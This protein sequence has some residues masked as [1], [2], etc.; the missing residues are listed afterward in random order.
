MSVA[1]TELYDNGAFVTNCVASPVLPGGLSIN[2]RTC[3]ISGTPTGPLAPTTYS[4]RATNS[5]GTSRAAFV[6]LSVAAAASIL[7]YIGSTGT[8]GRVSVDMS[9]TPTSLNNNGSA[10]TSCVASPALPPG[11]SI[12]P[13]TCVISGIPTGA[14]SSTTYSITA[15]NSAG[16]SSTASVTLSVATSPTLNFT[17]AAGTSG[18][19]GAFM[20]VTPTTL[21]NIGAPIISC[22]AS[23]ALPVGLSINTTSCVISGIPT[24]PL[25]SFSYSITATNSAGLSSVATVTLS[26]ANSP[27][28]LSYSGATGTSGRVGTP[29]SVIPTTFNNNG[30]AIT[31]CVATSALPLGLSVNTTTCVISGTPTVAVASTSYFIATT[32]SVGLSSTASV[33]LSVAPSA[34]ILSYTGSTGTSGRVGTPMSVTPTTLNNNGANITNCVATPALSVGLSINPI[35]CVISGTPLATLGLTTYSVTGTN[36]AGSSSATSVTL[37]IAPSAPTLDYN[38]ASGNSGRAGAPMSVTPT[39]LKNNG[40]NI[41]QCVATPAL[42][43]GLSINPNTC[44][45]SGTPTGPLISTPYSIT[46][47]N[48][49]GSSTANV[50]L[51]IASSAPTLSYTGATGTSGS[52]GSPMSVTPTTL[53]NNGAPLSSCIVTPALSVGLSINP[54]TCVISGTPSGT[55]TSTTYSVTGTNSFGTSNAAVVTLSVAISKPTLSYANATGTSGR[56]GALMSVAPT[57]INNNGAPITNCMTTPALTVGLS[58]NPTTCVI[59]G[60][61]SGTLAPTPYSVVGTNSAGSSSAASVTLSVV[62]L[63]PPTL[64]YT[65]A[66]GTSGGVGTAMEV[67][68]TTLNNN[69][70]NIINCVANPA[71]SVGLSINPTTCVISGTPTDTLA[72]TTY[73]VTVTNSAGL[74]SAASVTLSVATAAPTLSYTGATGTSG[75]VGAPMSV[76]PTTLNNNGSA[77]TN[78]VATP[79][80]TV[81]LSI[82][83]TTCVISG[84][85]TGALTSTTYSVTG[86][87]SVGTSTAASVTLSVSISAP[88]LSYT[89]ASG[90]LGRVGAP[91]SVTPTTRNNNGAPI[92]N[93]VATPAL[94]VGLS[95]NPTTCVI[96]GTPTGTL[97]STIYSI[98]ATNSA[99]SSSS[100]SVTLSVAAA[101]SIL[102]YTGATGTSGRVGTPMS[103]T[104][105]TL[106]NNGSA[107]TNCV[108]TPALSVGLSI[109]TT[110]CVISGIPTGALSSTTYSITATNSAGSSP[111]AS[112]TLIVD[113]VPT[114]SYAD[115]TGTSGNVGALMSVTPTTLSQNGSPITSCVATPALSVGLSINPNTCVISGTP[116]SKLA[117]T[118]YSVRATNSLGTSIAASVTLSVVASVPTLSYSGAT[119]TTGRVGTLMSVTPTTLS[120]NDA[121]ITN[122]VATPV[123]SAGLSIN[124]TTCVISGTP[125]EP[126]A[127]TTYSVS[128]TNSVG[129]SIPA[130][131]T[132]AVT[133]APTLSYAWATGTTG[134]V[135]ASMT[136]TP[137]TLNNNGANITNCVATPALSVGLSISPTTCVISGTPTGPLASTTY[138]VTATNSLGTSSVATVILSVTAVPTLSYAGATGISGNVG[139]L[140]SVTPTTLNNNG[141]AITNCVANPTLTVGL[142]IN[143]TTCVI[144]GTPTAT[145]PPFSYSITATNSLGTSTAASVSLSVAPSPPTISYSGAPGILGRIGTPMSVAPTTLNNNGATITNCVASPA[146]SVGLSINPTTCVISGTPSAILASTSYSVTAT[147]SA[148]SSSVASVTLSVANIPTIS[149]AGAPGT[150]GS[151]G[152]PMSVTPTTLNN[153]GALITNCVANPALSVGLSINPTTCIISGTPTGPLASTSYTITVTNS[154]GL[155]SSASVTLSVASSAPTISYNGAAGTLGNVGALMSVAPTTLNNNGATIINCVA[156][157]ALSVGLS[158]NPTTCIISGTPSGALAS[159]TYSIRAT[160]SLGTSSAA[161]VILS[162]ASIPTLSYTSATGTT[163][164]VGSLMTVNPTALNNNGAPITNC[165]AT[166]ALTVGL[167]INTTTCVISGTPTGPLAST[168]YSV[169]ATNSAG[170]STAASVNLS[171]TSAPTLSYTAASGT[172]GRVGTPMSVTP[173][174][175]NNNGIAITNCVATPALSVGLSINTTTCVISGTPTGALA[176]TIYSITATNSAGSSPVA[177]VTLSVDAVPT[178]SYAGATGTSGRV[179]TPMTV[180]PPTLDNNGSAITNCVA[181]PALSVGLSINATTCIIS[182]NPTSR[183]NSTA[184]NITATNGAG[185]SSAASVTLSVAAVPTITY[186]ATVNSG[187]VGASMTVTPTTLNNNGSAI[188]NCVASPALSVGLSINAT[189]CVI[190]GTPTDTLPSTTYSIEATNSVGTSTKA[191]VSL[192]V[193]L[194]PNNY[195]AVPANSNLGVVKAFCAA[196]FEMKNV[197]LVATSQ[198]AGTPWVSISQTDA[199]T[200][201]TNLGP[202]YD[203]ISNPEW[204]TIAREIEKTAANWSS[205]GVGNGM[206]N[207]GHSDSTPELA[208]E[209]TDLNNPYNET[210]NNSGQSAGSGW[211]QKRKHTFSNGQEIW[212]IAGNVPEWTDW[213]FSGGLTS[214]PTSCVG[215][216]TQLPVVSCGALAAAD[217]MPAN[218]TGV[219][220]SNYNSNYGLGQFYGGTGGAAL[221]GG[222]FTNAEKAGVFSLNFFADD[223]TPFSGVGFRCVLRPYDTLLNN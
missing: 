134:R 172:L 178:L 186:A 190:S 23:P 101:A 151:G 12:N 113:A 182:G 34:P 73:S 59:S 180:T 107:I 65:G 192:S 10:I 150:S 147:N 160:N 198:A 26:I 194:C 133:A 174:T 41:T 132:L 161:P 148:G 158:I 197:G 110:T 196:Q 131:V 13:T 203:L 202:G 204:M 125:T 199:K 122:C 33:T 154:A 193:S 55:L 218:T 159:T 89:A 108:A 220:A 39:T 135:G 187:R 5:V 32:N 98:T 104:P 144:S 29:M 175:L 27:P 200:A 142:S 185:S 96:S 100:A 164:N 201:C 211:E 69:G 140:M 57:T 63:A 183:L 77:I 62:I 38:G 91:M 94:T 109:N 4:I 9:V 54:N 72:L 119:G 184:Y 120:N 117:S 102:S 46:A 71:L 67:A 156:T 181:T 191:N 45:I 49:A 82:N 219:T 166:P 52:V 58:I 24:G 14:L 19:V 152:N 212:D 141:L 15:T 79:A 205:G 168:T 209:V 165:V 118:T 47:T 97:T 124:T 123:L 70:A 145:L 215:A 3:L 206:L 167:S 50:T 17:G 36:S 8:T 76:T 74:S 195:A 106:N 129:S 6:T 216:W 61:P 84:T 53:N 90:T 86:T 188:T 177:S 88:S 80:L 214:G 210:G 56:V 95:I 157:P 155:S 51:S 92:T 1:P 18:Q 7:S 171:V 162:V 22:V 217:Y 103:V 126:L 105:T 31:N 127:S 42:S 138:S 208:L 83:P 114:L 64:S 81:G 48:L 173:T 153:N 121:T 11:L 16:L 222:G 149:Y 75:R 85:P 128:A 87:N 213:S 25:N 143:A 93:C 169:R 163:G 99:G 60:T 40:S 137:T 28:I 139:A 130:S 20:S 136:V 176:T 221:R 30:S 37:S 111:A 170:S 78:C 112:V 44:V 66:T 35:T 223:N 43:V 207:R 146:L 189:T 179:G 68:P 21:N 115:A 2:N 116:S